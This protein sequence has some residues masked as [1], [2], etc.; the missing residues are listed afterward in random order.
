MMNGAVRS[1][2]DDRQG[3]FSLLELIVVLAII[4]LVAAMSV[5]MLQRSFSSQ[6]LNKGAD[7]VRS[8]MS[9]ARIQAM[10]TGEIHALFYEPGG[11]QFKV[12]EFNETVENIIANNRVDPVRTSN[13]DFSNG[14]LPKEV[15]FAAHDIIKDFRSQTAMSNTSIGQG[16]MEPILFYPDGTSQ[17]AT[18]TLQ[19]KEGDLIE[20][21]L[22]GLTG[23]A[24]VRK[25]ADK[26]RSSR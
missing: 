22:R 13:V 18:I 7:L 15:R 2:A 8:E 25:V 21:N 10:R 24:T 4:V 1:A 9:R 20:I 6:K 11:T 14:M 19:N 23:M 3:G 17:S 12:A 26:G 5:P 16:N